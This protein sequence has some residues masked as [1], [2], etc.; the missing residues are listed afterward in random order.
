MSHNRNGF[1]NRRITPRPVRRQERTTTRR[2]STARASVR[3]NGTSG[4]GGNR[5]PN[6]GGP[7]QGGPFVRSSGGGNRNRQ[8][9]RRGGSSGAHP[10]AEH[11]HKMN[12]HEFSHVHWWEPNPDNP[13]QI[14][15]VTYFMPGYGDADGYGLFAAAGDDWGVPPGPE[16]KV[17]FADTRGVHP[18]SDDRYDNSIDYPRVRYEGAQ[19]DGPGHDH[20]GHMTRRRGGRGGRVNPRRGRRR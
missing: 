12:K 14:G 19:S 7:A 9:G 8:I 3:G 20:R 16:D 10:P 6:Q 2:A 18:S 17:F 15:M 5:R 4:R 13:D 1:G 11:L